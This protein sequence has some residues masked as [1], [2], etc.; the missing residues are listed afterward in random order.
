MSIES[1]TKSTDQ[2]SCM[3]SPRLFQAC[4][5]PREAQDVIAD[6]FPSMVF[7]P[8]VAANRAAFLQALAET[9][10]EAILTSLETRFDES[11]ISALPDDVEI[12]AS[13]SAG[14]DHIDAAAA[15]RRNIKVV[16]VTA[17]YD[18][19]VAEIAMLLLISVARRANGAERVLRA[20]SWGG[21][22]PD[23]I[24]GGSLCNV[25]LGIVGFGRI[26]R[27]IAQRARAFEMQIGCFSPSCIRSD[28]YQDVRA[29]T[30]LEQLFRWSQAIVLT[31]PLNQE[32]RG[33]VNDESLAWL[34]SGAFLINVAR[35]D[36]IDDRAL[37]SA[38]ASG[39]I[40]GIG[41]DVFSGEP[42]LD[43]AYLVAE[44]AVVLPHIGSSTPRART[45]MATNLVREILGAFR[46]LS[47]NILKK[48]ICQADKG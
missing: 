39:H 40:A 23:Q 5:L 24:F 17:G 37:L 42:R 44:N 1:I 19:S 14:L 47:P 13:Y 25:R 41:L 36:L 29:F 2:R 12:L 27:A 7:R 45:S 16:G 18:H 11:M 46:G 34:P 20:G 4:K 28:S 9:P 3:L 33:M 38:L 22:S 30:S 26:G 10:T 6:A 35:G 48:P 31:C 21:W 32:T 15:A 8:D 43:P